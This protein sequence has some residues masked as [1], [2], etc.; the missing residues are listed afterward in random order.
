MTSIRARAARDA[1]DT[2]RARRRASGAATASTPVARGART[3][4]VRGARRD[5]AVTSQRPR[6]PV[7]RAD[8][9]DRR[10]RYRARGGASPTE[11]ARAPVARGRRPQRAA[12]VRA[13]GGTGRRSST[14]PGSGSGPVPGTN[15]GTP[16]APRRALWDGSSGRAR[17]VA[18][19]QPVRDGGVRGGVPDPEAP[20]SGER[21]GARTNRGT[22]AAPGRA[23]WGRSSG[24][25]RDVVGEQ[26]VRDGVVRG[27]VPVRGG[28][29]PVPGK[30]EP[31]GRRRATRVQDTRPRRKPWAT[32]WARSRTPSLRNSRRACVLTV[33]SDR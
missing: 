27:R 20:A 8:P 5:E 6:Q 4:R 14:A 9:T 7:A 10:S 18:G 32:A 16:T 30:G 31:G 11:R 25:A 2:C 12:D 28:T 13:G 21:A 19:K 1:E 29:R 22:P 23:L 24:R 3:G 17:D 26:P 15:R 33:S